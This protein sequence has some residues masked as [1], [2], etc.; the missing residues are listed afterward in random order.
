MPLAESRFGERQPFRGRERC[1]G[2]NVAQF[3]HQHRSVFDRGLQK[4]PISIKPAG[5]HAVPDGVKTHEFGIVFEVGHQNVKR[6]DV[7]N[8]A[9]LQT[10]EPGERSVERARI[11]FRRD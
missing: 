8:V 9:D 3:G 2:F 6:L 5:I 11:L 1:I 4:L 7:V 10:G